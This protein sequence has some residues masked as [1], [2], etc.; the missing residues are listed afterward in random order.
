MPIFA[1]LLPITI[2]AEICCVLVAQTCKKRQQQEKLREEPHPNSVWMDAPKNKTPQKEKNM[3]NTAISYR[4]SPPVSPR[5]ASYA[6]TQAVYHK[7]MAFAH[8]HP[9]TPTQAY[10]QQ[11][12]QQAFALPYHHH[13][14]PQYLQQMQ[15][16][17]Q[18]MWYTQHPR[19]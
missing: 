14:P 4:L 5:D 7:N 10:Q 12:Q 17:T 8:H 9:P 6:S 19:C 15:T 18:Q 2:I 16:P 13:Q 1:I 3:P 11:Q